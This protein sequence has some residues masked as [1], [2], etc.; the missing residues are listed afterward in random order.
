MSACVV[1]HSNRD[2]VSIHEHSCA[3]SLAQFM[4][5]VRDWLLTVGDFHYEPP[6]RNI[7]NRNAA[8]LCAQLFTT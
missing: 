3:F 2:F 6:A 4:V 8:H 7:D 5:Y 1:D